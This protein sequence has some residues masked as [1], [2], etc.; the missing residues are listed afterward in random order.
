M[1]SY[2]VA[3]TAIFTSLA[4]AGRLGL[5]MIPNVSLAIPIIIICSLLFGYRVGA[6]TGFLTFLISDLYIGLG[7]WTFI[8]G[9]IAAIIGLITGVVR[10]LVLHDKTLIFIYTFAITLFYDITTSIIN[11]AIF[12]INPLIAVINLFIP[13]FIGGIPY[14]M[15][16]IHE[17]SNAILTS[18]LTPSLIRNELIRGYLRSE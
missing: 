10:N 2:D 1:K 8:D 17:I 6:L 13:V 16:P 9:F 15:G 4:V 12:G 14:P 18:I 5:V 3:L 11:M 7:P